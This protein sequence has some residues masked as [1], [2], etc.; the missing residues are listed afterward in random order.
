MPQLDKLTYSTQIFWLLIFFTS[1]YFIILKNI[2]PS[3]LLNVKTRETIIDNLLASNSSSTVEIETVN[4]NFVKINN[5][6][7]DKL[8]QFQKSVS[9]ELNNSY[10]YVPLFIE[11]TIQN[12]ELINDGVNINTSKKINNILK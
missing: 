5:L 6:I 8:D 3:I 2:L 9:S 1:F 11:N 12:E 10:N 4:Q 7:L